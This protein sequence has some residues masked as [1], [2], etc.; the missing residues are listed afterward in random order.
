MDAHAAAEVG[1]YGVD[2]EETATTATPRRIPAREL[3]RSAE[4]TRRFFAIPHGEMPL[5]IFV[6]PKS[7][8]KQGEKILEKLR[9][10][11]PPEQV[12]DMMEKDASTGKVLGASKG[13]AQHGEVDGLCALVCGGDGTVGWVLAT[14]DEM[15]LMNRGIPV[16]TMP[17]GTGNDLARALKF[18]SGYNGT[19]MLK[20]L[21]QLSE[22]GIVRMDRW[23]LDTTVLDVDAR[24]KGYDAEISLQPGQ[25][26]WNNYF[27]IGS[28][29]HT[30][31]QFHLRREKKP[32]AYTS[33]TKNKLTYGIVGAKEA[34]SS[35]FRNLTDDMT[36]ICD[37]KDYTDLIK[38]HRLVSI[39][40][41]NI[42]S[43]GAGTQPWGTKQAK[44]GFGAP[45]MDDKL[46]E[47]VGFENGF[48]FAKG[49][50]KIGH[51]LRI[52]QCSTAEI[53]MQSPNPI[54]V[55]GEP[56]FLAA[57]TLRIG[58]KNQSTM[59]CMR[60]GR[61][62]NLPVILWGDDSAAAKAGGASARAASLDRTAA[63]I[64]VY[65]I[66]VDQ[67]MTSKQ[68]SSL[69]TVPCTAASTLTELRSTINQ[70]LA[71]E[72]STQL[73]RGWCFL[74]FEITGSSGKYTFIEKCKE[75][76]VYAD[77]FLHPPAKI[78]TGVFI[79]QPLHQILESPSEVPQARLHA[80][81]EAGDIDMVIN[82][83]EGGV[84][85]D[86]LDDSGQTVLHIAA[87]G[88]QVELI[89]YLVS[90]DANLNVQDDRGCTPL[91]IASERG[92]RAAMKELLEAGADIS[93]LDKAGHSAKELA[94]LESSKLSLGGPA[95]GGSTGADS[96]A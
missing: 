28:D 78:R 89:A 45:R 85:C 1:D 26:V 37:G 47:V 36:L 69:G 79:S 16:A 13:L 35:K 95:F 74:R 24:K 18:G 82:M 91:H 15:G 7:G 84:S 4:L 77:S 58:H 60:Q 38:R 10:I 59:L 23:R 39:A 11:V 81:A 43:F 90:I 73:S 2:S 61:F 83:I 63:V 5:L 42:H 3:T 86:A 19:A 46:V 72:V 17:L 9:K 34:I 50:M 56:C 53:T 70:K 64:D 75:D 88:N 87:F 71:A 66:A 96:S 21:A 40:F 20:L 80:A 67:S 92:C 48:A 30:A 49:Q 6:N 33:R 68:L 12:F 14:M 8:G 55:D 51:A 32:E 65:M 22:C 76:D 52:C 94:G 44:A 62:R 31:L 57:S 93:L 54:Q 25:N 41:L 27:S 29:A